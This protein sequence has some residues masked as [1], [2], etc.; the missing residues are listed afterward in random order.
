MFELNNQINLP[1]VNCVSMEN[2]KAVAKL[3]IWV[4]HG[5]GIVALEFMS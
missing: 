3:V 2:K 4:T 1:I 5:D